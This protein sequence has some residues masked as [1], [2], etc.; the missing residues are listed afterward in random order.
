MELLDHVF[1][2]FLLEG[3]ARKDILDLM[4]QFGLIAK[5]SSSKTG[6]NYFFHLNSKLRLIPFV[7]WRPQGWTLVLCLFT[8][9]AVLFPMVCSLGLFLDLSVGVLKLVQLSPLPCTKMERGLSLGSKLSMILFLFVRSSLLSFLS[10][11]ETNF[12]RSRWMAQVR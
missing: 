5:F 9:S 1:S 11:K 2:K 8:L 3:V 7:P 10:S 4:E 12:S 6:E